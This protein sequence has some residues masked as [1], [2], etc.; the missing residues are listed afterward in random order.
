MRALSESMP[1]AASA[2]E[3][4][5]EQARPVRHRA[6]RTVRSTL[7]PTFRIMVPSALP[8]K[9]AFNDGSLFGRNVHP[10]GAGIEEQHVPKLI[11][12][13]SRDVNVVGAWTAELWSRR[14][15]A[16]LVRLPLDLRGGAIN[17]GAQALRVISQREGKPPGRQQ[18]N[19]RQL[20]LHRH[21]VR[22][23]LPDRTRPYGF[24]R[25]RCSTPLANDRR[26]PTADPATGDWQEA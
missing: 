14:D 22:A 24:A 18:L 5:G 13:R 21:F 6:A 4:P 1:A 19:S 7:Q 2:F 16:G 17:V 12:H 25:D 23:Q 15:E 3:S 10:L 11:T 20:N 8:N 26:S 9:L